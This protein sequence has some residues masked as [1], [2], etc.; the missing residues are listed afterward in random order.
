MCVYKHD[1][2]FGRRGR[3]PSQAPQHPVRCAG[4]HT[5]KNGLK[6]VFSLCH[7]PGSQICPHSSWQ[8]A[9]QD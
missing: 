2:D 5:V 4:E 6:M 7:C 8:E 3:L 1:L 9:K